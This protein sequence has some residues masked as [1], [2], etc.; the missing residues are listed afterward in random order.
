MSAQRLSGKDA[1]FRFRAT[2]VLWLCCMPLAM[3]M[4]AAHATA[5]ERTIVALGD[6]NTSGFGVDQQQAFPARLESILRSRGQAVRVV[7]AGVAGDTFGNMA[8]RVD[9]SVPPNA[10]LV[11]VQGGFNDLLFRVP[12][13]QSA[14]NLNAILARLRA[15][16]VK[17]VLCGFFRPDWDAIG[18]RLAA[19]YHATF[20]PGSTCYDPGNRG[21]DRLH[22]SAAGHAVVAARLA[23]VLLPAAN[24]ARAARPSHA[25]R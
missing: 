4:L 11:I 14:A 3:L 12:P 13:D 20:V 24:G 16:R 8:R 18:R 6:S 10:S 15:R 19:T 17:T 22:M 2:A 7:N 5:A 25:V 9:S 21:L 1:T 23:R